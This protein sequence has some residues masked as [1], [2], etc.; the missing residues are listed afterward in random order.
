MQEYKL[1]NPMPRIKIEDPFEKYEITDEYIYECIDKIV[2]QLQYFNF[3]AES[4]DSYEDTVAEIVKKD[5]SKLNEFIS[6]YGIGVFG[7]LAQLRNE[8]R[9][10][11]M[12][13][14]TYN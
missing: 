4:Y 1:P 7:F 12:S 11:V 6:N 9:K 13:I 5:F 3:E 2:T 8:I 10:K 14:N